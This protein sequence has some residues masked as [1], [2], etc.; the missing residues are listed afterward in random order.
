MVVVRHFSQT[1]YFRA[2]L[3]AALYSIGL[4]IESFR[5]LYYSLYHNRMPFFSIL[6]ESRGLLLALDDYI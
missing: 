2:A 3:S 4:P 5:P 1:V 6:I